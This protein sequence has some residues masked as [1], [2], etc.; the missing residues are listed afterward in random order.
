MGLSVRQAVLTIYLLT[1]ACGLG[2]M[3][4]TMLLKKF[5]IAGGMLV[6]AQAAAILAVVAI[7]EGLGRRGNGGK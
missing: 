4:L 1:L 6:L 2:A 3:L 7:L 5:S